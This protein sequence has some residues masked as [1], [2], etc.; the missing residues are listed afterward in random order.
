MI[1]FD[2]PLAPILVKGGAA[3]AVLAG[4][5]ACE[6]VTVTAVEVMLVAVSPLDGVIH[7][8]ETLRLRVKLEDSEGNTLKERPVTWSTGN[9]A[10]AAVDSTGLVQAIGVGTTTVRAT[11]GRASGQST[12]TVHARPGALVK[13]IDYHMDDPSR[14]NRDLRVTV[15]IVNQLGEPIQG[16]GVGA[17]LTNHRL[18]RTWTRAGATDAE[19]WVVLR[20]DPFP[21]GCW[22]TRVLAVTAS[23]FPWDRHTPENEWC[24]P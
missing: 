20:L 3:L 13:S 12:I 16:A 14:S 4:A 9:G 15:Q 1:R 17:T 21:S 2:L 19:G 10:V 6:V 11:A 5:W 8:G 22:V 24:F 18:E 7:P 23:G